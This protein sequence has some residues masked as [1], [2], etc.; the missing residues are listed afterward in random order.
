[1]RCVLDANRLQAWL[2]AAAPCLQPCPPVIVQDWIDRVAH[3]P[4]DGKEGTPDVCVIELGG[5]VGDIESMPFIEALRQ[6]QFRVGAG[7]FCS[8]HVSLV[9]VL[10]AVGEQ[11]TKPTQHSV[12]VLR[13]LGINPHLLA[14]RSAEPLQQSVRDKLVSRARPTDWCY[15]LLCEPSRI[16][17]TERAHPLLL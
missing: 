8:V 7:N 11:K 6:F 2:G 10:G 12:A 14:C 13:S 3:I 16:S 15:L 17:H 1:M 4:V 9:P 5:T